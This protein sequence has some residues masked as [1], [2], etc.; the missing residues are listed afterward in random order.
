MNTVTGEYLSRKQ[1]TFDLN[2]K[3]LSKNYPRPKITINPNFY[4]KAYKD[5]SQFMRKN[6]FEHRQYS[7]YTSKENLTTYDIATLMEKLAREMS[8]LYP[9][10]NEIDV[11]DIGEQ[12]SI[13]EILG[14]FTQQKDISII[15]EQNEINKEK[16][17]EESSK[18]KTMSSWMGDINKVKLNNP[19]GRE[20]HN[21]RSQIDKTDR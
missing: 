19:V 6:G 5:I 17:V 12:H 20:S 7:V 11:T 18:G 4:K 13:K 21:S 9:C 2:Q 1:I 8:W 16:V 15:K 10:V 14:E 3:A